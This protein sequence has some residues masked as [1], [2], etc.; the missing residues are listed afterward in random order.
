V[1]RAAARLALLV[2]VLLSACGSPS[3]DEPP[4]RPSAPPFDLVAFESV[5]A[6]PDAAA[7]TAVLDALLEAP[8]PPA[9]T[10]PVLARAL[11]DENR[12]VRDR[13]TRALARFGPEAAPALD[14]LIAALR[15]RDGFVR[16][17]AAK[18]LAGMGAVAAPALPELERMAAA[19][20]ETELGRHWSAVAVEKIRV[21]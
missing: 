20:D 12:W 21:E 5:M 18:A 9:A 3:S 10:I 11:S 7:R 4:A 1:H 16:W 17:R 19:T 15:D 6:G 8:E 13:A 14:A 2:G